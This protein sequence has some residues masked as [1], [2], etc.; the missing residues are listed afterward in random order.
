[1]RQVSSCDFSIQWL[2]FYTPLQQDHSFRVSFVSR[3]SMPES[4]INLDVSTVVNSWITGHADCTSTTLD[5]I[6]ILN[7]VADVIEILILIVGCIW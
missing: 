1:M 7:T 5:K 4:I 6:G 3:F 2:L